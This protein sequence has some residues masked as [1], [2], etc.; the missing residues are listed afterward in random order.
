[1]ARQAPEVIQPLINLRARRVRPGHNEDRCSAYLSALDQAVA[2]DRPEYRLSGLLECE[3]HKPWRLRFDRSFRYRI[4][5]LAELALED[6][7]LTVQ[8]RPGETI[9]AGDGTLM[10]VTEAVETPDDPPTPAS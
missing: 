8:L 10:V 9:R 5:D 1:M 4:V 3:D 7:E 2:R 6:V